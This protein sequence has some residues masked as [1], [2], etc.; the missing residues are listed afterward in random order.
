LKELCCEKIAIAL[1]HLG[2]Q[3]LQLQLLFKGWRRNRNHIDYIDL[4]AQFACVYTCV[5]M[6]MSLLFMPME[7]LFATYTCFQIVIVSNFNFFKN[8][9]CLFVYVSSTVFNYHGLI[10]MVIGVWWF[11]H[12]G[13]S[14]VVVVYNVPSS[15]PMLLVT[16]ISLYME[17]HLK[18]VSY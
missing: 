14:F 4:L 1:H 10:S 18:F 2:Y 11:C 8:H 5:C 15:Y 16:I 6:Y 3:T 13:S 9:K 12:F 17:L 7:N